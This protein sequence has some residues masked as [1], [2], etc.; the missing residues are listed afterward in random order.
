L[1]GPLAAVAFRQAAA[2]AFARVGQY[3]KEGSD[4]GTLTTP[5]AT[6]GV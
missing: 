5:G 2:G 1:Q 4:G 6:V 3:Q